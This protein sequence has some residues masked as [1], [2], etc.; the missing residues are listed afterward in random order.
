MSIRKM[1][2][3]KGIIAWPRKERPRERL[4]AEG[5]DKL[6]EAEL[7]AIILRVGQGTFKAGVRGQNAAD[8]ARTLLTDFNGLRGLDRAHVQDLL[9]VPGLGPAKVAQ[10]KAAFELGRK[11]CKKK[12]I[13]PSFESS[14]AIARHFR[15]R[16]TGKDQEIVI[17]VFLNGQNQRLGERDITEGTPTQATL[18]V[19]RVIEEA[20]HISAAAV[21]LVHNHP[22]GSPEPSA[23]DDETTR[24]L[25]K[26]CILVQLVLLDHVIVG[27]SEHYSY[28]DEGRLNELA[29]E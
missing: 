23:G 15:P 16:F 28:S 13:A 2:K 12:L 4:L 9:K 8:L 1:R 24:D 18:Y 6:T 25:L 21:V 19:R 22:S 5:A 3:S 29:T 17:A 11:V 7:L 27:E 26:A 20:L 14:L 10:I